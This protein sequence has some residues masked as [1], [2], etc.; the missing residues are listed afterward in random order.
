[1]N[2]PNLLIIFGFIAII[3]LKRYITYG[4]PCIFAKYHMIYDIFISVLHA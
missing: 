4:P 2:Q 1:M 3:V